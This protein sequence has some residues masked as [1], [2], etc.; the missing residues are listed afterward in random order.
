MAGRLKRLCA[1]ANVSHESVS[2]AAGLSAGHVGVIVNGHVKSP[3]VD[4]TARIARALGVSL[5]W[6]VSGEGPEPDPMAVS[7]RIREAVTRRE[8]AIAEAA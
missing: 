3:R 5:D 6:L 1:G 2:H 8:R 7:A 4:A